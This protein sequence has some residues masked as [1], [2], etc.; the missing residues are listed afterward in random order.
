MAVGEAS[1]RMVGPV[2]AERELPGAGAER[3]AEHLVAQAD[4][5]DGDLAEQAGH[6]VHHRPQGGGVAGPV[7]QEHPVGAPG[8]DVGGRCGRRDHLDVEPPGGELGEDVP[9]DPEVVGDDVAGAAG[10]DTEGVVRGHIHPQLPPLHSPVGGG[11]VTQLVGPPDWPD[12]RRHRPCGAEP[13]GEHAGVHLADGHDPAI[14]EVIG[15][16]PLCP[17]ARVTPGHRPHHQG[18]T[19]AGGGL[20]VGVG[21]TVVPDVGGGHHHHLPGVRGVGDHLLVAGHGGVEDRFAHCHP[22]SPHCHALEL[23]A[24]G[25][26]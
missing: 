6:H 21:D 9:L 5:E 4:P 10:A 20:V 17:P 3:Q 25:Q 13:P 18:G 23:G 7:G 22:G 24:V 14:G 12:R 8:E 11:E 1:H 26:D 19:A 2:V 16:R 15:Q